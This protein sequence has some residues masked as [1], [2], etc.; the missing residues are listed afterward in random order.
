MG[1]V[2]EEEAKAAGAKGGGV[3]FAEERA[4]S[5]RLEVCVDTQR[6]GAEGRS[7]AAGLVGEAI[8]VAVSPNS[9]ATGALLLLLL[10]VCVAAGALYTPPVL[11]T[12]CVLKKR[13]CKIFVL[14]STLAR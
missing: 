1:E 3:E 13:P 2:L 5:E 8:V 4:L 12:S 7:G 6:K 14:S 10:T 9:S 11:G